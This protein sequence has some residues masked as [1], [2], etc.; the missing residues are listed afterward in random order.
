MDTRESPDTPPTVGAVG[1]DATLG[2]RI[3]AAS[4]DEVTGQFTVTP[5]LQQ[6]YGIVHG[7]VYCSVIESAASYGGA[8]W[9]G[10]R[11]QVVGVSNHTNFLRAVREGTLSLRATPITRGRTQQLWNVEV[12]EESGRLV[13]TGQVRLANLPADGGGAALPS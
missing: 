10:D 5:A 3:D 13:A 12:R 11:G 6:P 7:G 9:F 8:L 1:F 2:L 4:G